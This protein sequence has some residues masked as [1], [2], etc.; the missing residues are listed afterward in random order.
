MV[1]AGALAGSGVLDPWPVVIGAIIGAIFG[2]SVSYWIGLYFGDRVGR[3]WPFRTHPELLTKGHTFFHRYGGI[4]IALGRFFGPVRA[5]V[6]LIAGMMEMPRAQF[7]LWNV[8]SAFVWAPVVVFSGALAGWVV[9]RA[10][11]AG[12][13]RFIAAGAVIALAVFAGWL[14]MSRAKSR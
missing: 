10:T 11:V 12:D 8:A 7:W 3:L 9:E 14:V 6:P 4:S 1:A 5:V 2:D 13:W